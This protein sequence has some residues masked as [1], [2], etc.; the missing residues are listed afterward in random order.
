MSCNDGLDRCGI[1]REKVRLAKEIYL[2]RFEAEDFLPLI[3]PGQFF[4]IGPC[5]W[6]R[7]PLLLRPF[8][9]VDKEGDN[10]EFLVKVAGFGTKDII[11][12]EIGTAFRLRGPLGKGVFEPMSKNVVLVAGGIG[13]APLIFAQKRYPEVVS[14]LIFGVPDGDWADVASWVRSRCSDVTIA[15]DDGTIG[16]KGTAAEVLLR[17]KWP[18]EEIWACGPVAMFKAIYA[19]FEGKARVLGSFESRMGCGIGGCHSCSI[20]VKNGMT[21]VCSHGPVFDMSEVCLDELV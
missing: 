14:S 12:C 8:A 10:I 3:L 18:I 7:D 4:M 13:I 9:V 15:C 20:P 6:K 11:Q 1:L 5:R 19:E 17:K 16:E 2:L 21:E